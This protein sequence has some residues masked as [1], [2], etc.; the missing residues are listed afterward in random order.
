MLEWKD[1]PR[2]SYTRTQQV[3]SWGLG[4]QG[5]AEPFQSFTASCSDALE[6]LLVKVLPRSPLQAH[7]AW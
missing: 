3:S 6:A 5:R 7:S 1:L 2:V 4:N